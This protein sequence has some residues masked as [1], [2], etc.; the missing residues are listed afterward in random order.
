M[1][2]SRR[3][4]LRNSP[5]ID[6]VIPLQP[7]SG[8]GPTTEERRPERAAGTPDPLESPVPLMEHGGLGPKPDL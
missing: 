1:S 5:T 6:P 4:T 7:Q 2:T 3:T 8:S